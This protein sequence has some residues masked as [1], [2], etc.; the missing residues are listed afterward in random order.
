MSARFHE[1][2]F[3]KQAL[4]LPI[5]PLVD[6]ISLALHSC[7]KISTTLFSGILESIVLSRFTFSYWII[8]IDSSTSVAPNAPFIVVMP[9]EWSSIFRES[10]SLDFPGCVPRLAK[11]ITD[12]D[13]VCFVLI[14]SIEILLMSGQLLEHLIVEEGDLIS[15]PLVRK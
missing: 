4:N 14:A 3:L 6:A 5:L 11:F 8:D 13:Q 2:R 7:S 12:L 15:S 10:T 1:R 9:L